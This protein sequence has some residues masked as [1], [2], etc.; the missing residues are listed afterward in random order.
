MLDSRDKKKIEQYIDKL[1]SKLRADA[2]KDLKNG[3]SKKAVLD[4]LV[5]ATVKKMTPES[6][7]ILSSAYNM[8]MDHTLAKELYQDVEKKAAYY[9][10]DIMKE[11]NN[12]FDFEVPAHIDYTESKQLLSKYTGAGVVTVAGGF[13]SLSLK[14]WIPITIAVVIAGL[15]IWLL[16]DKKDINE[17]VNVL[18]D[19][20]LKNVK[21]TLINWI[22]DI[23]KYYDERVS[24]L[25]S[26]M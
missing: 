6:K 2:E 23:E 9:E 8:M 12:K 17:D 18:I 22:S 24:T 13:V 20:Y 21:E 14:T 11:L 3:V 16:E 25:E 4:K 10:L 1:I 15:M 19:K 5:N 7:S 26:E